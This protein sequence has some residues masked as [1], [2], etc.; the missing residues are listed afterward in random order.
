M[1]DNGSSSTEDPREEPAVT[2]GE[3]NGQEQDVQ[4]NGATTIQGNAEVE[5]VPAPE[6]LI[7][8]ELLCFMQ[9]Y[10]Q[11][12]SPDKIKRVVMCFY[13]NEQIMQAKDILWQKCGEKL[14]E[15]VRRR[16]TTQRSMEEANIAD[17]WEALDDLDRQNYAV[18]FYA[19]DLSKVPK[20]CPEDINELAMIE[21]IS[22]L[23]RKFEEFKN[24][25]SFNRESD[26]EV[27]ADSPRASAVTAQLPQTPVPVGSHPNTEDSDSRRSVNVAQNTN[28][29]GETA[30]QSTVSE[31]HAQG[32]HQGQ[33]GSDQPVCHTE[34]EGG[35]EGN[36]NSGTGAKERE[37]TTGKTQPAGGKTQP[38]GALPNMTCVCQP[39]RR[40]SYSEVAKK[41]AAETTPSNQRGKRPSSA[42]TQE[43]DDS[44][45]VP[46]YHRRKG[47]AV[48]N[49][50]ITKVHCDYTCE[51]LYEYLSDCGVHV[52]GLYQRSHMNS[53]YKS[54]VVSIIRED[55]SKV[56]RQ[57][58]WDEGIE[59]RE[60]VERKRGPSRSY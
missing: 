30:N 28:E 48:M 24:V 15:Y 58:L 7:H 29:V 8:S 51:Q 6:V 33:D 55:Y 46:R 20:H 4:D 16:T 32:D 26:R 40:A 52:R 47:Q 18:N 41:P 57:E 49:V 43:S 60:Y 56:D 5:Q 37:V 50:F 31:V 10:S 11:S 1:S 9:H 44:F 23:E 2:S 53:Y 13:D 19:V 39:P 14:K 21:R 54:F 36:H 45:Q 27:T 59:V 35:P 17:I 25:N 34:D 42:I 38:A 22:A 12:C 3:E